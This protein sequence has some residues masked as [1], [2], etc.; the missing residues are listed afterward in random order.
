MKKTK[1]TNS[2]EEDTTSKT[3]NWE[4]VAGEPASQFRCTKSPPL[5][6]RMGQGWLM[7]LYFPQLQKI[8][9]QAWPGT[10]NT[11]RKGFHIGRL[12]KHFIPHPCQLCSGNY[13][14]S[15]RRKLSLLVLCTGE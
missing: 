14:L 9:A 15:R 5:F 8:L 4:T 2:G 13:T 11:I 3:A 6:S 12:F 1:E 10:T 7:C